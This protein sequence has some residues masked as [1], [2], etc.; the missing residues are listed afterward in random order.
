[1]DEKQPSTDESEESIDSYLTPSI[2]KG[3]DYFISGVIVIGALLWVASA[4]FKINLAHFVQLIGLG[5]GWVLG[6]LALLIG[7]VVLIIGAIVA[8]PA[9][10]VLS[11]VGFC[12]GGSVGALIGIGVAGVIGLLIIA[13]SFGRF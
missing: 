11:I 2:G 5:V 8:W 4:V 9:S 3:T 7:G 13:S 12:L 1:M 6:V 10:I